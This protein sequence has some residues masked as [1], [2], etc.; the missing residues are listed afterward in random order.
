M[1][2]YKAIYSIGFVIVFKVPSQR[3]NFVHLR[4]GPYLIIRLTLWASLNI[5]NLQNTLFSRRMRTEEKQVV[6]MLV[7]SACF[8]QGYI[9]L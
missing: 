7:E 6:G 5:G 3:S 4:I 9:G 1:P 2:K 8:L